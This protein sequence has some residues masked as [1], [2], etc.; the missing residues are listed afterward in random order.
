M[1]SDTS[2]STYS[3]T[4]IANITV[5][6]DSSNQSTSLDYEV[7]QDSIVWGYLTPNSSLFRSFRLVSN[8]ITFGKQG[9]AESIVSN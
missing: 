6:A 1:A 7:P 8:S 5:G 9:L 4:P 2:E 3:S